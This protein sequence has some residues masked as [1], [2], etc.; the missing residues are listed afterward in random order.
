MGEI[1]SGAEPVARLDALA[2]PTESRAN[3]NERVG[4]L[5]QRGRR[6]ERQDGVTQAPKAGLAAFGQSE[7][8][9]GAS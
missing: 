8:A 5:E 9:Q 6:F 4:A 7:H 3:L 1:E 2:G